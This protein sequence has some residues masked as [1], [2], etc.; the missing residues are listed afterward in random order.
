V[1][2]NSEPAPHMHDTRITTFAVSHRSGAEFRGV[3]SLGMR[4]IEGTA[5]GLNGELSE[6]AQRTRVEV[7]F[8]ASRSAPATDAGRKDIQRAWIPVITTALSAS[9]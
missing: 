7:R 4:L 8:P 9:A 3:G 5:R 1:P 6:G 2:K